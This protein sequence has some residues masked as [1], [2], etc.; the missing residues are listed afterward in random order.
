MNLSPVDKDDFE[1]K[2]H[3]NDSG[4]MNRS[5]NDWVHE[6]PDTK[7]SEKP[8]TKQNEKPDVNT[9]ETIM[10][11]FPGIEKL[12]LDC[13][14]CDLHKTVTNKVI[15]KGSTHPKVVFI[16]EAP[17]KNEDETGIPFCGRAGKLLDKMIDYMKLKEEDWA[18]INTIKCRP[19]ENRTPT[20]K[21]I[22][23]CRPFLTAQLN[24]MNPAVIILLGNTAEK[25]FGESA[26]WGEVK[27]TKDGKNIL[28]I[29][30]PAAMIY[31]REREQEQY[32]FLDKYK[33][34]WAD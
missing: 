8:D 14:R 27:K 17:G 9:K 34:L 16:G 18:V 10:E 26:G 2:K 7:Q 11:T 15:S 12:I 28:K 24:L 23:I 30:H 6:K 20:V 29:F 3:K 13:K 25:A 32:A 21:E 1:K 5:L 33:Y 22:E 19:P 31:K 4:K